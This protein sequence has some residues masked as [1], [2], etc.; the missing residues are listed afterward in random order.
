MSDE[1]IV[2]VGSEK[3][4]DLQNVNLLDLVNI[5]LTDVEEYR[6]SNRPAGL[7]D[8]E[9]KKAEVT[10]REAKGIQRACA[11]FSL[12]VINCLTLVD[13]NADPAEQIGEQHQEVFWITDP[14]KSIGQIV[15]FLHDIGHIAQDA[16]T[17]AI[18]ETPGTRF[19]AA[20]REVKDKNDTSKVYS[21]LDRNTVQTL[22]T[23]IAA[24]PTAAA[25]FLS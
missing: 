15:A 25:N 11:V 1:N 6:F 8:W 3:A 22:D 14:K 16:L 13:K 24:S 21:N 5:D 12:E 18:T 19:R 9:I 7:Y 4:G 2:V 10:V 20:M 23:D 17:N